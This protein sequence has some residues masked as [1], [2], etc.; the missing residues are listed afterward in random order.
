MR[1][2]EIQER[3]LSKICHLI[4]NGELTERGFA[5]I[6]GISQP[7]IHKVLKGT[8]TLS[9]ARFDLLLKSLNC[10]LLDLFQEDELRSYLANGVRREVAFSE[11]PLCLTALGPGRPWAA[12][13]VGPERY[14]VPCSLLPSKSRLA[15]VRL[16]PDAHMQHTLGTVSVAALELTAEFPLCP[17]ALYAVDRG[18]DVVI[19]FLRRGSD[20]FYLVSDRNRIDPL[21]WEFVAVMDTLGRSPIR[22]RVVWMNEEEPS[23][24][25]LA[26]ATSSYVA[27]T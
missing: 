19:R 14:P 22:G 5:R 10:S 25:L 11:F 4:H 18:C 9:T 23:G 16:E 17:S 3:L 7:H 1:F 8:R 13:E 20:R 27:R 26:A 24:Q 6:S 2:L 12:G 21:R 15:L